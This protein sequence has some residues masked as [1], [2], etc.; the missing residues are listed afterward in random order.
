MDAEGLRDSFVSL[1]PNF[2]TL[3]Y[4]CPARAARLSRT[5]AYEMY[6]ILELHAC[7]KVYACEMYAL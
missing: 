2:E 5:H 6:A 7:L 3:R 4:A 1:A